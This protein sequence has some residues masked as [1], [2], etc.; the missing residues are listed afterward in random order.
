M[1][2]IISPLLDKTFSLLLRQSKAIIF[3]FTELPAI[4]REEENEKRSF[5][6]SATDLFSFF[7][8]DII[9]EDVVFTR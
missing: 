9:K 2:M 3:P 4:T 7:T 8:A 6:L 1:L 5:A